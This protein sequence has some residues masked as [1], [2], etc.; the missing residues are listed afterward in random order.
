MGCQLRRSAATEINSKYRLTSHRKQEEIALAK[1]LSEA[2]HT[3]P[4]D[5]TSIGT[6]SDEVLIASAD[7][8]V[9]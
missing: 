9:S 2:I 4:C 6:V 8:V 5:G 1:G 3:V 7:S